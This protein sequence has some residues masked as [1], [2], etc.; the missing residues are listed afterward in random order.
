MRTPHLIGGR[1]NSA[2]TGNSTGGCLS[3][4]GPLCRGALL[5]FCRG[6][7]EATAS[8]DTTGGWLRSYGLFFCRCDGL[9]HYGLS[10]YR[11]SHYGLWQRH[12]LSCRCKRSSVLDG[13]TYSWSLRFSR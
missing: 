12:G 9:S 7:G 5:I 4:S 6:D 11:L 10:Y 3:C 2:R 8:T 13:F 1:P